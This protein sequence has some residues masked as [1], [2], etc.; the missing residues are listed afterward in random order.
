VNFGDRPA[1]CIT[2]AALRETAEQY[3]ADLPIAAWYLKYRTYVD[4]AVAGSDTREG[5]IELLGDWKHWRAGA[6]SSLRAP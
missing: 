3:G 2:I 6:N 4:D 5:M 1:G